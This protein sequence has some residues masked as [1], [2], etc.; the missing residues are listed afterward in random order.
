VVGCVG[1]GLINACGQVTSN[2]V[3]TICPQE[4]NRATFVPVAGS[5][6][7]PSVVSNRGSLFAGISDPALPNDTICPPP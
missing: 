2:P 4:Y 5:Y 7:C 6:S 3:N 1:G